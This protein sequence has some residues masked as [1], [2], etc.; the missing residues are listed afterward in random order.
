MFA[1]LFIPFF[2]FPFR[3]NTLDMSQWTKVELLV[4]ASGTNVNSRLQLKTNK[5]GVIWLD[6]VSV[7][8]LETYKVNFLKTALC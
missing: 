8:P 2:L 6:Q 5:K 1:N 4:R 3:S 7:M